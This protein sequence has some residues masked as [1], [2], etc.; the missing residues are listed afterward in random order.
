M[1]ET[2]RPLSFAFWSEV[3]EDLLHGDLMTYCWLYT[4]DKPT[5]F[6]WWAEITGKEPGGWRTLLTRLWDLRGT[7]AGQKALKKLKEAMK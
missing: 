4:G 3:M 7:E 6:E 1:D 2:L 5:D